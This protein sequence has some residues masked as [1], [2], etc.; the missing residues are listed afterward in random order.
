MDVR[1]IP[2]WRWFAHHGRQ[3]CAHSAT[4][5]LQWGVR[6]FV[7]ASWLNSRR[8]NILQSTV[9]LTDDDGD[10][11]LMTGLRTLKFIQGQLRRSAPRSN[12]LASAEQLRGQRFAAS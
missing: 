5:S 10:W 6:D 4:R 12:L 2:Q 7:A 3:V 11:I 1:G 9:V 8:I